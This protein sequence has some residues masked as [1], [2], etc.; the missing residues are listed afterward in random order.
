MHVPFLQQRTCRFNLILHEPV[1]IQTLY[2]HFSQRR[3]YKGI[4]RL[5]SNSTVPTKARLLRGKE[6]VN[7]G[8][9]CLQCLLPKSTLPIK[10]PI[11]PLT[12][13]INKETKLQ[14]SNLAFQRGK[15]DY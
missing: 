6:E 3:D 9:N 13:N 8:V 11:S 1:L 5:A 12:G 15:C 2:L 14:L 7:S 4:R 10:F